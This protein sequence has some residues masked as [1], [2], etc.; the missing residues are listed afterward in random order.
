M[1]HCV[2]PNPVSTAQ[3]NSLREIRIEGT[4]QQSF[5][6]SAGQND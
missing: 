6:T 4:L 3:T 2:G 1:N 5:G